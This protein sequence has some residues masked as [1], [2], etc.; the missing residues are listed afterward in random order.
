MPS[1]SCLDWAVRKRLAG[2]WG[3]LVL[4]ATR[5]FRKKHSSSRHA[6]RLYVLADEVDNLVHWG[7]GI[8]D[9]GNSGFF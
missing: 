6:A 4:A 7:A 2:F 5:D 1:H 3:D 8:E 9:A